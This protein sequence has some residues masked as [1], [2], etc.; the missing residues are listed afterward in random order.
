[1][2]D[3]VIPKGKQVI[4]QTIS[5]VKGNGKSPLQNLQNAKLLLNEEISLSFSSTYQPVIENNNL[6]ERFVSQ[7]TQQVFKFNIS[8]QFKEMGYQLWTKTE[9]ISLN[10]NV[11]L[12]MRTN[13]IKDVWIPSQELIKITLPKETT[14][15]NVEAKKRGFGLLG[16]GPTILEVLG[17]HDELSRNML[18]IEIGNI[19]IFPAIITKVDPTYSIETDQYNCPIACNLQMNIQSIYTATE[20]QIN[21]WTTPN[22]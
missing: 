6:G 5:D 11:H 8:G 20:D 10:L 1:M 17:F 18:Y 14:P 19:V 15:D 3:I 9:P 13:A 7:L 22:V 2:T 12:N 21:K 16:P 4:I